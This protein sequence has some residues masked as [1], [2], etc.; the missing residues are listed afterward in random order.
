MGIKRNK[1]IPVA[2]IEAGDTVKPA[3]GKSGKVTKVAREGA[4]GR[5]IR[6]NVGDETHLTFVEDTIKGKKKKK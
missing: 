2:E 4:Q 3:V 5:L 1:D 6:I